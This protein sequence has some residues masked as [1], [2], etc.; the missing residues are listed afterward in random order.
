MVV[1]NHECNYAAQ[2]LFHEYCTFDISVGKVNLF[3]LIDLKD[4]NKIN[5]VATNYIT[6]LQN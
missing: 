6:T 2:Q 1:M 5:L 3:D 4:F